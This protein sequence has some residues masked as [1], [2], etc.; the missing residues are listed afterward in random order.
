VLDPEQLAAQEEN[1]MLTP[2]EIVTIEACIASA[3]SLPRNSLRQQ[4]D[5][6]KLSDA[7][8]IIEEIFSAVLGDTFHAMQRPRVPVKHSVRKMFYVA[9]REAF[10][11]GARKQWHLFKLNYGKLV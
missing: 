5:R 2:Q 10:L 4:Y 1:E 6:V 3:R 8:E 11:C 9:L 7:P